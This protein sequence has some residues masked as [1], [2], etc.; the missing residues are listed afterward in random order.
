MGNSELPASRLGLRAGD[1]VEVRSVEEILSS[2]DGRGCLEDL[3][4]MPEMIQYCGKQF[5]VFKSAHKTCDTIQNY[6]V[7]RRMTNAVHLEGLRCDGK[8]H[9]GCQAECLLFWKESWLKR[10]PGPETQGNYMTQPIRTQRA[11]VGA[12][13]IR[14]DID[15]LYRAARA[16]AGSGEGAPERYS[17]QATE[18]QKATTPFQWWE[19]GPYLRDLISGNVSLLQLVRCMLIAAFN[20]AMRRLEW[21]GGHYTYPYT[22]GFVEGKTP[23]G[24]LNLQPGEWIQVRSKEEI[25]RTLIPQARNRGL[26]FDVEMVPYCG[27]T[28]R[29]HSRVEQIINEKTGVMM[30]LH[31]DCMI[32]EGVTCR[33]CYSRG[34]LFCPRSIYPYWREIWLKRVEKTGSSAN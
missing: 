22:R 15:A 20:A 27:K 9:G 18:M 17:C 6:L 16:P 28:F 7:P 2:L 29:V 31:N 13:G 14:C 34:R 11:G 21:R 1:W 19:P 12:A 33:G 26:G 8:S 25:R 3:P 24:T 23:T 5:K 32:L 4:F 30:K 10:V